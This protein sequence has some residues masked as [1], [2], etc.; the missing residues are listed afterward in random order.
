MADSFGLKIGIEGEREFKKAIADI[1]RTFKVLGSEMTLVTSLFDKND[2]SVQAL[3]ARNAVLNKEIDAQREKISTLKAALDNASTSFGETD[4]RTQNWQIQLNKAQAQLNVMTK[5]LEENNK[6]IVDHASNTDKSEEHMKDAGS[7]ANKLADHVDELSD[8]MDDASKKTSVFGDVLKANLLSEAIIG[9]VKALG[10]AIAGIGKAFVGAMK[11]GIQYNAELESYTAS[12]T[13]MLG[14]QAKAQ[15]LVN[16]LRN[17]AAATPFGLQ[18]LA[19]AAQVLMSFGMS[20]ED[21]QKH[22]RQLGDISQGNVDNFKSLTLAFAQ[23]SSTGKLTGQDLMQM[24]N[25]GFNP[26]EEI[27]RKTGKSIGE[28]KEEMSKGSIS[29][30]MLADAFES[31][32]AEGGRFFGA[33]EAQSMTLIGQMSTL[34]DNIASLKGQLA[35]G[36]SVMLSGTVLPM[37]NSWVGELSKAFEKDGAKGLIQSFGKILQEAVQFISEQLPLVV[38]MASQIIISLVEGLTAA[39]PK[40]AEAA[41]LLLMTLVNGLLDAL[42]AVT[43]AAAQVIATL[44]NG[45]GEALPDLIPAAV[46]AVV[47]IVRGL[48]ENLPLILDAALQ[49]ITRLADGILI[50]L[51]ILISALPSIISALVEFLIS[52]IPQI[53]NTGIQLLTSLVSAMPIIIKTIVQALPLIIDNIINT[54]IDS[55]PLIIEAGIQLLVSLIQALPVIITTIVNAI[56]TIITSIV[57]AIVGNID[58]IILAGVQLLVSLIANLPTIIR[59]IIKAVP[60]IISGL[61]NAFKSYISEMSKIGGDL[62]RGLWKGISDA[63]AWLK[64]KVSGFFGNVVGNIKNFFGIRSPSELFA[65]IGRNL[66]EGIGVGFEDAMA[67]VSRDMQNAIPTRFNLNNDS[68]FNQVGS[69]SSGTNITQNI[70]VVSPKPMSEKELAREFKNLSR[71]LALEF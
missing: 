50:A 1:N 11:D 51:P 19:G 6:V 2:N 59:E 29:A 71:K 21:A 44:V 8:E 55:I 15:D 49:L 24:I 46:S 61:V 47:E 25:A 43:S 33:M 40:V 66:G 60:Q 64:D 7:A 5:E 12:F 35:S 31:A 37:V 65:G 69:V 68:R 16:N 23:A 30:Q 9:G 57:N 52:A 42:P 14:D 41:L 39:L 17:E 62:I 45:I 20:A 3:T 28:L 18:D 4:R 56:P 48:I 27:S 13:T 36:L 70:S 32:T 58:K 22:M 63:G 53:I 26:L 34:Q 38:D 10:S 67:M 54:V